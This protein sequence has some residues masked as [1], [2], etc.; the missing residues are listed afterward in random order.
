M[1]KSYNSD[2]FIDNDL[3]SCRFDFENSMSRLSHLLRRSTAN[4]STEHVHTK[5][6]QTSTNDIS[7]ILF[8]RYSSISVFFVVM[9]L[10]AIGIIWTAVMTTAQI[11]TYHQDYKILQD[12]QKQ[13]RKLQ[14]EY[15]RLLIEQQTFSATPQIANR[16]V[17]ELGMYSPTIEDK[18][19]IQPVA[20]SQNTTQQSSDLTNTLTTQEH[21]SVSGDNL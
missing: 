21:Q 14:V 1:R 17:T 13:Q 4:E 20:S 18:L 5:S 15:Q 11:Q 16:A 7:E 2:E 10:I 12:M 6:M 19:I 8:K 3:Y 9:L